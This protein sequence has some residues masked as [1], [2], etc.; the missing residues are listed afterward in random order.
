[1]QQLQVHAVGMMFRKDAC[2]IVNAI[3]GGLINRLG[4]CTESTQQLTAQIAAE[5]F[6]MLA[7]LS[8]ALPF[9]VN[10]RGALSCGLPC[11]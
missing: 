5:R 6:A 2:A 7:G 1:M 9:C 3:H 10:K 8:T 4:V 11:R